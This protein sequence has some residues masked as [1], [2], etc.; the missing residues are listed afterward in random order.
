M[1]KI[2]RD[3]SLRRVF[4]LFTSQFSN[5]SWQ[6]RW[7]RNPD[8]P[9]VCCS[10]LCTHRRSCIYQTI[11]ENVWCSWCLVTGPTNRGKSFS[12]L[13]AGII[14]CK[15][16]KRTLNL[17]QKVISSEWRMR[18]S[19]YLSHNSLLL[20]LEDAFPNIASAALWK[21][22]SAKGDRC[23]IRFNL[24]GSHPRT[25]KRAATATYKFLS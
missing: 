9:L 4:Q 12:S 24:S 17:Q 6:G 14:T 3:F 25:L 19:F 20:L 13:P 5:F 21:I 11:T 7:F 8:D 2:G 18:R 22:S 15:S 16:E 1:L 23:W 10:F